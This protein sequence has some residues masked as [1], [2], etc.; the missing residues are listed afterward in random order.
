[1][2]PAVIMRIPLPENATHTARP[3]AS[4]RSNESMTSRQSA[5]L[6][7]RGGATASALTAL[8]RR[9]TSC[10]ESSQLL[11]VFRWLSTSLRSSGESS[12][13]RSASTRVSADLHRIIAPLFFQRLAQ[14]LQRPEHLPPERRLGCPDGSGDLPIRHL[15]HESQHDQLARLDR[16]QGDGPAQQF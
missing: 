16:Q 1:M 8:A 14:Q 2:V 9:S 5:S 15:F 7:E 3:P 4:T 10:S 11:H 12:R 13:V 6:H